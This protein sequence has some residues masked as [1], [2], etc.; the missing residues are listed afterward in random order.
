VDIQ[1]TP[2]E[3]STDR[4]F[5]TRILD[6]LVGNASKFSETGKTIFLRVWSDEHHINFSVRDQGPGI[7]A[8]DRKKI[9]AKF[10]RLSAK[11]T[12]GEASTGLGLAITKA[13]VDK[14][15]GVIEVN[16]VL[17]EGAQITVR[18]PKS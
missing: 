11:P 15:N 8:D 10:Q 5:L 9:F 4:Q 17:G 7:S 12:G 16:S 13:L 6:N 2:S 18:L 14:L 3:V 1:V